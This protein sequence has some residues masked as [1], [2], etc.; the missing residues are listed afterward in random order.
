KPKDIV[1]TLSIIAVSFRI[2][3]SATAPATLVHSESTLTAWSYRGRAA[4]G[5]IRRHGAKKMGDSNA[6]DS[7]TPIRCWP[8]VRLWLYGFRCVQPSARL[9]GPCAPPIRSS[10]SAQG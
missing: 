5:V 9:D 2:M 10:A 4:F 3:V 6:R 7:H 1:I 8:S